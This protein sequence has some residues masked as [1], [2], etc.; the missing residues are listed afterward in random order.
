MQV[1]SVNNSNNYQPNFQAIK[2]ST[3]KKGAQKI[4]IFSLNKD[5]FM[6]L[7]K[8]INRDVQG[9]DR[10]ILGAANPEDAGEVI[11]NALRKAQF[12]DKKA[13]NKV[14][15]AV[16][17]NKVTGVID[18]TH[19]GDTISGLAVTNKSKT[20]REGLLHAA[21]NETN[22]AED[23]SLKLPLKL[24]ELSSS[25][26]AYFKGFDFMTD[27][28]RNTLFLP[29]ERLSGAMEMLEKSMRADVRTF[30]SAA[31]VDLAKMDVSV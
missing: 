14:L 28:R 13:N 22:K 10:R 12:I 26:K 25:M 7:N 16:E 29:A 21:F 18:L 9:V 1:Q 3:I 5:D 2:L 27:K 31:P 4:D 15:V 30:K 24:S 19:N 20:T 6:F 11:Q 17:D 8:M 23:I